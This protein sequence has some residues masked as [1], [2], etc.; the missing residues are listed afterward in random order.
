MIG[1]LLSLL[2]SIA[3]VSASPQT[4][5]V[6][7]GYSVP[8]WVDGVLKQRSFASWYELDAHL[9][10]YCVRGDFDGDGKLDF[11][12][13]IHEK[14]SEK[15]GIVFVHR[16]PRTFYIV[17]AGKAIPEH[18]DDLRWVD[19]WVVFDKGRVMRGAGEGQP[20]KLKG[21]A[22]LIF[23]TE[24]ASSILWWSGNGYAWY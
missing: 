9:N 16:G 23:K 1:C 14:K 17:G 15:L 21:D 5:T 24:A 22:L 13:F 12:S 19:A 2:L 18:G 8:E 3:G 6:E 7:Q 11:A 10:P 4:L 20:P